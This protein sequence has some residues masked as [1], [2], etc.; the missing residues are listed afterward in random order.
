MNLLSHHHIHH[1][2]HPRQKQR[3]VEGDQEESEFGRSIASAG[4]VN[5]D[6]YDDVIIGALSYTDDQE[7]EGRSYVY[8]GSSTGLN[9]VANWTTEGNQPN[10][11]FGFT[12]ASTGDV[13]SDGYLDIY[14]STVRLVRLQQRKPYSV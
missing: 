2:S 8:Y 11:L 5:G 3:T 10:A 9:T 14:V 12:V 1:R 4:D 13:N 7:N 6:G